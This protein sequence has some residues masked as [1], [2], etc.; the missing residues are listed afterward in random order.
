MYIKVIE[1]AI[2]AYSIT[3][4]KLDNPNTSFPDIISDRLLE[5]FSVYR[6]TELPP[7][8]INIRTE[9]LEE[10]YESIDGKWYKSWSVLPKLEAEIAA[11]DDSMRLAIKAEAQ[12]RIL[13][14]APDWK[15]RNVS[16]R[17]AEL[18]VIGRSN[19]SDEELKE[20]TDYQ[21]IWRNIELIRKKSDVLE[22]SLPIPENY[23]DDIYWV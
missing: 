7:P 12:R 21:Q 20:F 16:A 3:Q 22:S 5:E 18:A 19:W 4:L 11:Y 15:Q 6:Y 8:N 9:Y 10:K 23:T 17:M 2:I 1:S 13:L 14:I